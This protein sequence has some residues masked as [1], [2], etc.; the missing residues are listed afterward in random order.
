VESLPADALDRAQHPYTRGL[1][2]CVPDPGR[3]HRR[4]PVLDR[5]A[6]G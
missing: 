2:A 6:F 3:P 1:L 5:A 4:L